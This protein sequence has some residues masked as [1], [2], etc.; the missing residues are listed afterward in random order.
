[1]PGPANASILQSPRY[2]AALP[3][4]ESAWGRVKLQNPNQVRGTGRA[5]RRVANGWKP[6]FPTA[7]GDAEDGHQG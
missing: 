1:M 3:G 6:L 5:A 4:G 2:R 7:G